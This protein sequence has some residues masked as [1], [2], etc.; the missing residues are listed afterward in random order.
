MMRCLQGIGTV[1]LAR[2]AEDYTF[3][4]PSLLL[5]TPTE[6][7]CQLDMGGA[8]DIRSWA[9]CFHLWGAIR[10]MPPLLLPLPLPLPNAADTQPHH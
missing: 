5:L 4:L 2:H 7:V 6:D 10:P 3:T 8:C 9:P 1:S